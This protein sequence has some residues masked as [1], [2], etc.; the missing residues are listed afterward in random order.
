MHT[1]MTALPL[2]AALLL[3]L[4]IGW[5]LGSATTQIEALEAAPA[6]LACPVPAAIPTTHPGGGGG[7][8]G[9]P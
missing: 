4:A 3:V 2:L 5:M 1:L 6:R 8:G 9:V 7:G